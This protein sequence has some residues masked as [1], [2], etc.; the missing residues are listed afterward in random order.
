MVATACVVT[1]QRAGSSGLRHDLKQERLQRGGVTGGV[2]AAE[3]E[4]SVAVTV[5]FHH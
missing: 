2:G 4:E 3:P 1:F 5:C